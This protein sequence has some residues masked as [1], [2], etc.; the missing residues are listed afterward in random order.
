MKQIGEL[1]HS[2]GG[3]GMIE[4]QTIAIPKVANG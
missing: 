4:K 3:L 1:V 2:W